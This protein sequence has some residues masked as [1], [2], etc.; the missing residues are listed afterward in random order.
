MLEPTFH[1]PICERSY[2]WEITP[3]VPRRGNGAL[4]LRLGPAAMLALL[5]RQR[6]LGERI[7]GITVGADFAGAKVETQGPADASPRY[8]AFV[9]EACVRAG[10]P[11]TAL[12]DLRLA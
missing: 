3:Q 12:A 1:C 5:D 8:H 9:C 7:F 4:H 2:G 11:A 10:A 6:E